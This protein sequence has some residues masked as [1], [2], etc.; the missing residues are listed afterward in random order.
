MPAAPCLHSHIANT[1][2]AEQCE[3]LGKKYREGTVGLAVTFS[4]KERF[5][6][7]PLLEVKYSS[8]IQD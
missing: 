2:G 7:S 5:L 8:L 6:P 3:I 1:N 4:T